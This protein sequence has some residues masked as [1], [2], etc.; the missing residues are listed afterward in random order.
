MLRTMVG[1]DASV[2]QVLT[3]LLAAFKY[4]TCYLAHAFFAIDIVSFAFYSYRPCARKRSYPVPKLVPTGRDMSL[5]NFAVAA[6]P[7]RYNSS[8]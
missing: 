1:L 8:F 2:A 7:L 5:V 6:G 4:S 3:I